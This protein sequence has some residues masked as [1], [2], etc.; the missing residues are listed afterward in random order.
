MRR[1]YW[2]YILLLFLG[3]P[4][5]FAQEG[6]EEVPDLR[7]YAAPD[8]FFPIFAWDHLGAWGDKH[9]RLPETVRSMAECG[10]T[11]SGFVDT[12]EQLALVKQNGL[13]CIYDVEVDIFNDSDCTE[14]EI[15]EL[16]AKIDAQVKQGVESTKDDPAVIG[17]YIVDEPG[18]YNNRALAAAVAA[19][20][21]YAPGKMAYI[22]LYPCYAGKFGDEVDV[23][24]GTRSYAEYLERFVREVKPFVISYDNYM[25]ECSEDMRNLDRLVGYF[26]D[27]FDVRRVALKYDLPFWCIGSSL[28]QLDDSTPPNLTRYAMQAYVPLAAGAD[29]ITWFL[30][31]PFIW[32][33]SPVNKQGHKTLAWV[34]LRDIN[35][36]IKIIGTRLKKFRSTDLGMTPFATKEEAP[37]WPELP[38][39]PQNVLK[40]VR[41]RF[42]KNAS[43]ALAAAEEKVSD[44]IDRLAKE[45]YRAEP[46]LMIGEFQAR[47]GNSIAAMAVNLSPSA[48]V[49]IYFDKPDGYKTL[50]IVSPVDGWDEP[51]DDE[52][53]EDGFWILPGHGTLFVLEP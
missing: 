13:R 12:P 1:V 42:S 11:M 22:N 18:A 38:Q 21:K 41:C 33:D 46:K 7:P 25:V 15:A 47:E 24:L 3:I 49:K 9:M 26:T 50:K 31:F 16:C 23:A 39:L 35:E 48:A 14:A 8:D 43:Q 36:Q 2:L 17:Y 20:K 10:M 51:I 44:E 32:R 34:Y 37:N 28:S 53:L 27:I 29:G 30:Y 4:S 52:R 5:A 6:A 40:N 19:V 45:A